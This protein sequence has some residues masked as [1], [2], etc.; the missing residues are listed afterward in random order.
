MRSS[1]ID[2]QVAIEEISRLQS[3]PAARFRGLEGVNVINLDEGYVNSRLLQ[4]VVQFLGLRDG[5]HLIVCAM[6]DE[7]GRIR[8]RHMED[9]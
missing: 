3:Q 4:F 8:F 7:E 1:W 9:R 6:H 2:G 5:H